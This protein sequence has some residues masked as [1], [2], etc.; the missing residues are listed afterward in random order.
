VAIEAT[1]GWRWVV[2]EL[3]AAG[4]EVLLADP[5]QAVA[6]K[7]RSRRAKTDRLDARWLVHLLAKQMLPTSWLPPEEVQR[8]RDLTRF[9]LA[10][11]HDRAQWAQRLHAFLV[12]EGWACARARLLTVEG[13]R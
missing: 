4:I 7:G 11:S 2:R 5:G 8:L 9:R 6:L 1:T 10:L 3:Q 12:H 13:R